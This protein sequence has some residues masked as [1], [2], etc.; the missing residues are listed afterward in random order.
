MYKNQFYYF[1]GGNGRND[2]QAY[3]E[4]QAA[5]QALKKEIDGADLHERKLMDKA[6]N[7]IVEQ[8]VAAHPE[9][10]EIQAA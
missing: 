1:F 10:E 3:K 4:A 7:W 2:E 9:L 6:L 8:Y 5:W